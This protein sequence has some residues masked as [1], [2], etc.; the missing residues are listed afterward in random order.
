MPLAGAADCRAA[1]SAVYSQ[2]ITCLQSMAKMSST[3]QGLG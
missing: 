2:L 3:V 1:S